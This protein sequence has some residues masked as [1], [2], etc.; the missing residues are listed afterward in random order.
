MTALGLSIV[1]GRQ[2]VHNGGSGGH[3]AKTVYDAAGRQRAVGVPGLQPRVLVQSACIRGWMLALGSS[4]ARG[5]R[6]CDGHIVRQRALQM[7]PG[8]R[9]RR[10][11]PTDIRVFTAALGGI[12][13][14]IGASFA[15]LVPN[16]MYGNR[17]ATKVCVERRRFRH[18]LLA[19]EERFVRPPVNEVPHLPDKSLD[20]LDFEHFF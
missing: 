9:V 1:R 8:V 11:Q 20:P 5:A 16:C 12:R 7:C 18:A 10:P 3:V 4:W 19:R 13:C 15:R 2:R 6:E 17:F 14:S